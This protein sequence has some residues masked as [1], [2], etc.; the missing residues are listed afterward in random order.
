M[1]FNRS[2]TFR[3]L[4]LITAFLISHTALGTPLIKPFLGHYT[5][6]TVVEES[7]VE[8]NRDLDVTISETDEGFN[9]FWKSTTVK[10][11]G[12]IKTKDFD[13]SFTPT[14]REHVFQAAQRPSLFGGTKPLDPMKGEPY[15]WARIVGDTLTIFAMLILDDGGYELQI[16]NRSLSDSGLNLEYSRIRDGEQLRTIKSTLTKD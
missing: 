11:D 9:V 13:I 6:S 14:D 12:R 2:I 4:A 15:V 10:A 8:L 16:Y 3:A 5:G 7:G 1:E